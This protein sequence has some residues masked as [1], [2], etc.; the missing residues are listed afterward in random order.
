MFINR[1]RIKFFWVIGCA[2]VLPLSALVSDNTL[3]IKVSS[4]SAS[5]DLK[6]GVAM[7][8]GHVKVVQGNRLLQGDTLTIQRG[9]DGQIYSFVAMGHP[10]TTQ[11]LPN[12][13]SSIVH[14]QAQMIYY[15]PGR[16]L[17]EY[18]NQA[19]FDQGGNIFEGDLI[20]Y[21]LNTQVV[22]SPKTARDQRVTTIILPAYN[23]QKQNK[24]SHS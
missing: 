8:S 22:S 5:L 10:A 3:P 6:Q 13:G 23:Q 7:Y 24:E 1:L 17:V 21:N 14:G 2:F 12:I 11:D 4:E 18:V 15:Y 9:S 19:H 16:A 20:T